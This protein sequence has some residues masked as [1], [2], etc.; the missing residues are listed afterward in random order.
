[1]NTNDFTPMDF[2]AEK[3]PWETIWNMQKEIFNKYM[4][5]EGYPDFKN[6]DFD[7][8]TLEDQE[9]FKTFTNRVIEE[10]CEATLDLVHPD[11]FVEEIADALNFLVETYIMYGY[12]YKDLPAWEPI[13]TIKSNLPAMD[14]K[15]TR[16]I[17]ANTYTVVEKICETNNLLKNRKWK[18]TQYLVDLLIFEENLKDI[19]KVFNEYVNWCGITEKVLFETWSNKRS[20]NDFRLNS[21]Y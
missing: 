20:V 21:R 1:M 16:D 4:I 15:N 9:L 12:D 6:Y 14:L 8:N 7:I 13:N 19:F 17:K 10:L 11:H 3:N 18:Q 2:H 5:V